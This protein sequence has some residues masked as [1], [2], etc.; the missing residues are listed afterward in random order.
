MEGKGNKKRKISQ[1]DKE[2]EKVPAMS[3]RRRLE[4]HPRVQ[5]NITAV[6]CLL[7]RGKERRPHFLLGI[8]SQLFLLLL[9]KKDPLVY[10]SPN[11]R[12][13]PINTRHLS[14][15]NERK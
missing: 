1:K 5:V 4:R 2:E 6:N 10:L 14:G 12:T 11:Q 7:A 9:R 13:R 15:E 3:R 8:S